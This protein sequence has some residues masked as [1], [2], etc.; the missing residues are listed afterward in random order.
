M[1][2]TSETEVATLQQILGLL[3]RI[4]ALATCDLIQLI[5]YRT[6][7]TGGSNYET[8]CKLWLL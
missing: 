2:T 7:L 8:G 5:C 1:I 6:L 4:A 3:G